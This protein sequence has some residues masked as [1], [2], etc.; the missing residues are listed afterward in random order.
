MVDRQGCVEQGC[1]RAVDDA[2]GAGVDA[3]HADA[4][5]RLVVDDEFRGQG[6]VVGE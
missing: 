3:P 4:L 6:L 2:K 5:G 1:G